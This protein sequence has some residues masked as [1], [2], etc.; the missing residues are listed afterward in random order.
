MRIRNVTPSGFEIAHVFPDNSSTTWPAMT[1]DYIAVTPGNHTL[2]GQTLV[3]ASLATQRFQS[4]F[5]GGSWETVVFPAAFTSTPAVVTQIQTMANEAVPNLTTA[6]SPWMEVAM[7]SVTTAQMQIALERAETTTGTITSNE[8]I[9]YLAMADAATGS[10]VDANTNTIDFEVVRSADAI[11][12]NCT[13]VTYPAFSGTP[14]IVASQNTRDGGDG[15]WIRRCSVS[16]G[17]TQLKIQEDIA[18][19]SDI[20]H[21]TERAGVFAFSGHFDQNFGSGFEMQGGDGQ[22]ATQGSGTLSFRSVSFSPVFDSPPRVFALPTNQEADPVSLRVR[23][24]TASGFEIAQVQPHGETGAA[25]SMTVDYLAAIDGEYL[26]D[27]NTPVEVGA[28][29]TTAFQSG[30]GGGSFDTI[31]YNLSTFT[32]PPVLLTQVQTLNNEPL[33]DPSVVSSPWLETTTTIGT[34]ASTPVALERAEDT[35]GSIATAETIAFFAVE[36]GRTGSF[37]VGGSTISFETQRVNNILGTDNG[38][39]LRNYLGG[40]Y[41]PIP[42]VL[43][44]QRTRN[45]ANG[46]WVRRCGIATGSASFQIDEDRSNDAERGHIAEDVDIVVFSGS[47]TG[48]FPEPDISVD[49]TRDTATVSTGGTVVYTATLTNDGQNTASTVILAEGVPTYTGLRMDTYGTDTPFD[50][51]E[52]APPST[53]TM[54]TP[55]YSN[56]DGTTFTYD[57]ADTGVDFNV[58]DWQ[59]PFTGQMP[60]NG[61]FQIEFEVVAE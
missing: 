6:S 53:L 35:T 46:G 8:T 52:G 22:I 40:T 43:A 10:F 25:N 36:A 19:D 50:F 20:T 17:S 37:N 33:L 55:V 44:N 3:A 12:Q 9:A 34:A 27:D 48:D 26:L 5:G 24:I 4:K 29:S 23:N 47:F 61:T 18:T 2:A 7:Q 58:T 49:L 51:S 28:I 11:T 60:V 15:G 14:V 16:A 1:I 41:N 57:P 39:Y 38:C 54:G 45:G 30:F 32:G 13:S 56:D 59:I 42:R 21:T 31:T